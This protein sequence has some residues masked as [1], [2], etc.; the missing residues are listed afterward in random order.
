MERKIKKITLL[1]WVSSIDTQDS[2]ITFLN[3]I[4]LLSTD[5]KSKH[6]IL[7]ALGRPC[8][9]PFDQRFKL[10]KKSAKTSLTDR[11]RFIAKL[12]TPFLFGFTSSVKF[13]NVIYTVLCTER[14]N[15]LCVVHIF[16]TQQHWY[17]AF[18]N[19]IIHT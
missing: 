13:W 11:A 10:K 15:L 12:G 9:W 18:H 2:L 1:K 14:R 19:I 5:Q 6:I 3:L 16:F 8:V 7:Y 4:I 17:Y